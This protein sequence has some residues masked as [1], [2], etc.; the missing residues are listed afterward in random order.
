M[1]E[2]E[3]ILKKKERNGEI[4]ESGMECGDS[5]FEYLS[6]KDLDKE[7]P[8]ACV[9]KHFEGDILITDPCYLRDDMTDTQKAEDYWDY[10]CAHDFDTFE[11][12]NSGLFRFGLRNTL[13]G[14]TIYGDWSCTVFRKY[15][16][17]DYE[18]GKFCAD[19]GLVG[20]FL[21]DEVKKFNPNFIEWL[22]KHQWCG[23]VITGFNGTV[24]AITTRHEADKPENDIPFLT[25][26][27]H[28]EGQGTVSNGMTPY[29]FYT[30]Q[31]GY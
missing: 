13:V 12:D 23:A 27:V 3:E 7:T 20:V 4:D 24:K 8:V 11:T 28:L 17:N 5:G 19:A 18:V 6:E 25:H 29:E 2:A 1:E 30:K 14:R 16:E 21:L 9:E 26:T 15:K 10:F 31:T 22:V